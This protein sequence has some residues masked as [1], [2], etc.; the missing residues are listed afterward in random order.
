MKK[1]FFFLIILL[2]L[3]QCGSDDDI[4]LSSDST[5]RLKLKFRSEESGNNQLIALDSLYVD[6]DYG[7]S[8]LTS[9]ISAQADVDSV[10]V[11][12]RIDDVAYTDVY[13]RTRKNGPRSKLRINYSTKA[14]YVS[15][16]CGF[17]INYENLNAELLESNP[18]YHVESN[19]TSLT[20]ENKIN[21]YLRF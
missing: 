12:L 5:P 13:F 8:E 4:C 16:A 20:D 9:V 1:V 17:K 14:I 18:V 19:N 11:P 3:I 2:T 10:F 15:P 6:V 7:K 21:F